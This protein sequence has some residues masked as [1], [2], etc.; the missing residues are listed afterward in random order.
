MDNYF[1]PVNTCTT[2]AQTQVKQGSFKVAV[3]QGLKQG[4]QGGYLKPHPT[5]Q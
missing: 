4:S 5:E 2:P 3:K 1:N